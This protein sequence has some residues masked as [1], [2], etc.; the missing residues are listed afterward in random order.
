MFQ[1]KASIQCRTNI[2][3][4]YWLLPEPCNPCGNCDSC[5]KTLWHALE[6]GFLPQ[7]MIFFLEFEFSLYSSK[8]KIKSFWLKRKNIETENNDLR[9]DSAY[10]PFYKTNSFSSILSTLYYVLH[11]L[12]IINIFLSFFCSFDCASV[13]SGHEHSVYK[14]IVCKQKH[15]S[16]PYVYELEHTFTVDNGFVFIWT[17]KTTIHKI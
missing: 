7:N 2:I 6:I 15:D 11:Y 9:F 1:L 4:T 5:L 12:S 14:Y 8:T 16:L 17:E 3:L 10:C 13:D